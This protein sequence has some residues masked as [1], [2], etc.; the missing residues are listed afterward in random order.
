M[1]VTPVFG[2]DKQVAA[3]VHDDAI[4]QLSDLFY[5]GFVVVLLKLQHRLTRTLGCSHL[6]CRVALQFAAHPI[7][8]QVFT[9]AH[10]VHLASIVE[11]HSFESRF[12]ECSDA[13]LLRVGLVI[14]QMAED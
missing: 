2:G 13:F 4:E 14:V 8:V 12:F 6:A 3:K 11:V 5:G 1:Y 9:V 7:D 10:E